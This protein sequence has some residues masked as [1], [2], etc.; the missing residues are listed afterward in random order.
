MKATSV[1]SLADFL[2]FGKMKVGLWDIHAV[3]EYPPPAD[4]TCHGTQA[5]PICIP[6][7][8][9]VSVFIVSQLGNGVVKRYRRYVG[10]AGLYILALYRIKGTQA[11]RI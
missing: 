1:S 8:L 2:Y 11:D 10:R 7:V 4:N 9:F 5:H 3:Y 6:Q